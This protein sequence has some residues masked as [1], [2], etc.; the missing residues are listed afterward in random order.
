MELLIARL[1]QGISLITHLY[2]K[3]FNLFITGLH[4]LDL[5]KIEQ[6]APVQ[7]INAQQ[8]RF[9]LDLSPGSI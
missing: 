6:L 5:M 4:D 9:F 7:P 2:G 1:A 8:N 3:P